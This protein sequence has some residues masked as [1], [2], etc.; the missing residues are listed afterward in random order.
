MIRQATAADIPKIQ[1]LVQQAADQGEILPRDDDDITRDLATFVVATNRTRKVI[2]TCALKIYT[3]ELCEVRSLVV[4]PGHRGQEWGVR[5][6][7]RCIRRARKLGFRRAFALTYRP[8]FFQRAGFSVVDKM[9]FPQKVWKDCIY[10]SRFKDCQEVAV[11][12]EL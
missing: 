1:K 11:I 3:P 2:G 6:L 10:C 7:R 8:I 4:D 5:L 9:A 12:R